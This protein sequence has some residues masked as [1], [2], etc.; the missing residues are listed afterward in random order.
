VSETTLF[1]ESGRREEWR[2]WGVQYPDD[3]FLR[4][5]GSVEWKGRLPKTADW[6]DNIARLCE[7]DEA[8]YHGLRG[9]YVVERSVVT[10]TT[11]WAAIEG[12]Q[13]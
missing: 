1:G 6:E 10:Y 5:P 2:E 13:A 7:S 8:R 4:P 9:C 11:D 12:R 3:A